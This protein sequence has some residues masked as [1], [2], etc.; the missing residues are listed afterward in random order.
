MALGRAIGLGAAQS[1]LDHAASFHSSGLGTGRP[2]PFPVDI[3]YHGRRARPE[4]ALTF[5]ACPRKERPEF[6]TEIVN[7][8][9]KEKTA[10]VGITGED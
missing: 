1:V 5:D 8:L 7:F 9:Q 4:I 3:L 2:Y 10:S 6:S